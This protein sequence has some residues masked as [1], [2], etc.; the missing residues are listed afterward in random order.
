MN[1][2]KAGFNNI[3]IDLIYGV[4]GQNIQSW[5]NTLQKALSLRRNTF[6]AISFRL[7]KKHLSIKNIHRKGRNFPDEKEQLNFFHDSRR[8]GKCRLHPL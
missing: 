5:K 4:H 3:G 8:I 6:P 7:E 2:Q 1:R